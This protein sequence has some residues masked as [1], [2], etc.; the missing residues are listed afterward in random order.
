M[1]KTLLQL[2]L[3]L[4]L[5]FNLA[6]GENLVQGSITYV[7][8][9]NAFMDKGKKAGVQIGDTVKVSR[10]ST[11]LGIARVVQSSGSSS[12]LKAVTPDIISWEIGDQVTLSIRTPVET[13]ALAIALEDTLGVTAPPRQV[14]LDSS[15]YV[16]RTR[17]NMSLAPDRF[18]PAFS[19]YMSARF[20]DRGGDSSGVNMST[21]SL[22]GQFKVMDLGI[23][24]L[25]A[26]V[27]L[28][29]S[30]SS[31]D[32]KLETSLYSVM[33]S[34]DNPDSP[35][36][37]LF[38]RVYHPLFSALGTI[39]GLGVTWRSQRRTIAVSGGMEA[40]SISTEAGGS[41]S[42]LGLIDQERFKWGNIE[43]GSVTEIEQG[44]MARNYL[45]LASS[46]K[47]NRNLRVRASS[48]F[49]LDILDQSTSQKAISL[50]RFRTSLS[51]RPWRSL[52]SNF[53]YSY[54]ENVIELLDTATTEYDL[55]TRHS[56]NASL[57]WSTP[58]GLSL[59]GQASLRGDGSNKD[60]QMYGFNLNHHSLFS[61]SYSFNSGAMAMFSYL[62]EGGRVYMTVGKQLL[63][64][65][66]MDVYDEVFFYKILGDTSYKIRHLPEIS[67]SAKVPGLQRLR[68][69]TRFEQEDGELLY[70]FSLSA[71]RQF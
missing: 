62:S 51:W 69:R 15:A 30:Q 49:D 61:S 53:R 70:R 2:S 63:P 52:S 8:R 33:L 32:N 40:N 68:L 41:R 26:S 36:S 60:I 9:D 71:S 22:Y 45:L 17:S 48:E 43:F 4:F 5:F 38:G 25:D 66:D 13:P 47:F 16:E 55:A 39:D 44:E 37:Y 10:G 1:K 27:Y 42:K 20:S 21:G 19:G 46:A 67:L 65:L 57:S 50:T 3:S 29:S 18:A 31:N 59:A 12:S 58:S 28:R 6:F 64:W 35:F 14:F 56:I 24:H 34:Y 23:R 7:S 11:E 54:R